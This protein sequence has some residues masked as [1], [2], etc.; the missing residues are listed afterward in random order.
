MIQTYVVGIEIVVVDVAKCI[1]MESTKRRRDSNSPSPKY[2]SSESSVGMHHSFS[3]LPYGT[4][5]GA[6]AN[7]RAGYSN[8]KP[9]V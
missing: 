5:L 7:R 6:C 3:G 8:W 1:R 4:G 9:H 2:T